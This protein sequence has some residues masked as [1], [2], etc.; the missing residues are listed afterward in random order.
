MDLEV[1]SK[2]KARE[3]L[4]ILTQYS[5]YYSSYAAFRNLGYLSQVTIRLGDGS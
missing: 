2:D 4:Q 3:V 1:R 5:R